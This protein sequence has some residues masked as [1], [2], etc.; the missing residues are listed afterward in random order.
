MLFSI[1]FVHHVTEADA[2]LEDLIYIGATGGQ[3]E[4]TCYS[5]PDSMWDNPKDPKGPKLS[6]SQMLEKYSA[7]LDSPC[8]NIDF[9][10]LINKRMLCS[11]TLMYNCASSQ[12]N[13]CH[14]A[15]LLRKAKKCSIN[16]DDDD[17]DDSIFC[18]LDDDDDDG[19]GATAIVVI[20]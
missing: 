4:A 9:S 6:R 7:W 15:L 8:C 12:K 11:C 14:G 13:E 5:I 19:G 2:K 16:V 1:H 18:H 20:P 3:Y 17:D 10:K